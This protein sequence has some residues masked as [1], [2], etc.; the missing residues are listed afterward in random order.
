MS[1]AEHEIMPAGIA[2][3]YCTDDVPGIRRRRAGRA[4]AYYGCDGTKIDD[5]D[6]LARIKRLAVPPAWTDVWIAP[7]ADCHIQATGRDAKGR[8]QYRYHPDWTKWRDEVK[9]DRLLEFGEALPRM[10]R[11]LALDLALDGLPREKVLATV[12]HLL[13][14][15]LVRVGNDEYAKANGS[16]G[17]TTLRTRHLTNDG[18]AVRLAF[19]AKSGKSQ[20]VKVRDRQLT[21]IM[22]R[23]HDLPGQRLFRYDDDGELR[24]VHSDDVNEY[25]REISNR[26]FTAKDFR[27]WMGT[28]L[29]A[30]ALGGLE[31]PRSD[32]AARQEAMKAIEAV[33]NQLNNTK[34]VCKRSYV[35]PDV[36]DLYVEGELP[37]LWAEGPSRD[38]R[39]LLAEER[40]LLHV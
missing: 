2:L 10:R 27:T 5:P 34:A 26:D 14:T 38:G 4:F 23:L 6:T 24:D 29:A 17:L 40:K 21:R 25:L 1:S 31:P 20:S 28:L 32:R 7:D 12:V 3:T 19:T 33:A 22:R 37:E 8:K 35:H 36:V 11:R 39:W 13:E 16:F 30:H 9:Y 15:T 18:D